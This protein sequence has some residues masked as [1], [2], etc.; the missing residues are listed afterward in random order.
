M[1]IPF[2]L[3]GILWI[4][5]CTILFTLPG[6]SFPKE[7]WLD[8]IWFDKWVHIG[9]ICLLVLSW[10]WGMQKKVVNKQKLAG[11]FRWILLLAI[12]YGVGMEFVQKHLVANRSFDGGDIIADSAGAII[13][14]LYSSRIYI[15]K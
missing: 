9:L 13:G 15:K 12:A 3:P 11:I 6:S 4:I 2:L 8:K 10:C 1:R 14:Y 5:L 7:D